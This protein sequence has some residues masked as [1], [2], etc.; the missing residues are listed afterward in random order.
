[1][2]YYL[3]F[4]LTYD[5][6]SLKYRNYRYIASEVQ[7]LKIRLIDNHNNNEF[8]SKSSKTGTGNPQPAKHFSEALQN[9]ITMLKILIV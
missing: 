2:K 7:C 1:M 6:L 3:P 5:P 4:T 8:P 9:C